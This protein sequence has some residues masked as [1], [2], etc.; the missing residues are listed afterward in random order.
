MNIKSLV[1]LSIVFVLGVVATVSA[2]LPFNMF[3]TDTVPPKE[4]KYFSYSVQGIREGDMLI[5]DISD[6]TNTDIQLFA[7]FDRQPAPGDTW[8]FSYSQT[9]NNG[10]FE[11][12]F[13]RF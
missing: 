6:T 5:A 11:R 8:S 2:Q 13:G 1:L 7:Q 12:I 9:I 4:W 3:G 10:A